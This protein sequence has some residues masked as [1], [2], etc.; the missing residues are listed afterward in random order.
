[1]AIRFSF[2]GWYRGWFFRSLKEL[3]YALHLDK[4]NIPWKTAEV[5]ELTV[6]YIDIYGKEKKHYADFFV[7]G[8]IIVEVKPR[9]HQKG[10][11]VQL[12]A[13]AMKEFCEK[14][15]YTYNMVSP[16]RIVKKELE[17]LIKDGKVTL[18]DDCKGKVEGYIKGTFRRKRKPKK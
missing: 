14:K 2:K 11:T 7:D 4:S 8:H 3:S 15:G 5:P 1:M 17:E 9:K 13:A 6:K 16:R 18:T 12:K 10:K